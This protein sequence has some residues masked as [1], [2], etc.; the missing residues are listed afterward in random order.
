MR[1]LG[2][3]VELKA[4]NSRITLGKLCLSDFITLFMTL[5]NA[6]CLSSFHRLIDIAFI[7]VDDSS[8]N[9][10]LMLPFLSKLLFLFLFN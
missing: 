4:I 3:V 10:T 8:V 2:E 6:S 5:V 1:E 9:E 7:M